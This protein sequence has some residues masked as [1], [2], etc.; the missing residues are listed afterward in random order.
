MFNGFRLTDQ[1]EQRRKTAQQL[2]EERLRKQLQNKSNGHNCDIKIQEAIDAEKES[3]EEGLPVS[4]PIDLTHYS[5]LL[6]MTRKSTFMLGK[7]LFLRRKCR[8][9]K[10]IE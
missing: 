9:V 2:K 3:L 10:S 6:L 1:R 5:I 8:V 7:D 4:N